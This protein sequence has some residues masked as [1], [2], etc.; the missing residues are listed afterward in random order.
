VVTVLAVA[1]W[2]WR[3]KW[4]T[5][6]LVAALIGVGWFAATAAALGW[7]V[8]A[9]RTRPPAIVLAPKTEARFAPLPDATVHFQATE[10]TRVA[11]LEDRGQWLFIERADGPQGWVRADAVGW[12]VPR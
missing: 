9:E 4:R 10:G 5:G 8:Y 11:V 7:Q 3:P 6:F 12:V 2:I 1:G